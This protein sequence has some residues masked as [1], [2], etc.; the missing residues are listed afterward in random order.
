[1]AVERT[2]GRFATL[3]EAFVGLARA[4]ITITGPMLEF[5]TERF[6]ETGAAVDRVTA[7][8]AELREAELQRLRDIQISR[9][10]GDASVVF[11]VQAVERT[12]G[13]FTSVEDA[14]RKLASVGVTIT[15]PM[16]ALLEERFAATAEGADTLRA[17]LSDVHQ[18]ELQRAR[19]ALTAR[20][21]DDNAILFTVQAVER[22]AGAFTSVEDA[23]RKLAD[24]GVVVTGPMLAL[25]AER[26]EDVS[27]GAEATG[28]AIRRI[29]DV[30]VPQRLAAAAASAALFG[31]QAGLAAAS[32]DILRDAIERI[33]LLDPEADVTEL[34]EAWKAWRLEVDKGKGE[35]ADLSG[36]LRDLEAAQERLAE[37][38]GE[39]PSE[40]DNLRA[41]FQA[42]PDAAVITREELE[43]LLETI[44]EL[45]S[46]AAAADAPEGWADAFDIAGQISSGLT[47]AL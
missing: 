33:L 24:A 7:A 11:T 18:A 41:A 3:E 37:L 39:A 6:G 4:G 15:A 20:F 31:N 8:L 46:A 5:L 42:A 1:Q 21:Q 25:L 28:D 19:D 47:G 45:E 43:R 14:M 2:Q 26:F 38:T 23:M 30:E 10:S 27:Q 44:K 29:I 16:L 17:A 34:M 9:F 22:T 35:A 12:T 13:E 32:A 36:V 40:W